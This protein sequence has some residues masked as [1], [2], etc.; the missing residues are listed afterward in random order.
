MMNEEN[1]FEKRLAADQVYEQGI[2]AAFEAGY[3][4]GRPIGWAFE[5]DDISYMAERYD[6]WCESN[7]DGELLSFPLPPRPDDDPTAA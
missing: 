1:E 4:A 7:K 6:D 3:R 5:E 2:K